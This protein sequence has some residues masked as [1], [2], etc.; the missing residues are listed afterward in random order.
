MRQVESTPMTPPAETPKPDQ[1]AR[2]KPTRFVQ[3]ED[4]FGTP[5]V[6]LVWAF[7]V[8]EVHLGA[9]CT[10]E[11]LADKYVEQLPKAYPG[12]RCLKERVPMDHG[13][14]YRDS[15]S[16]IMARPDNQS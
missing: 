15:I 6:W 14:A 2:P 11:V 13:F 16:R 8:G 1:M 9:I 5:L 12:C 3:L 4:G 10:T 7:K